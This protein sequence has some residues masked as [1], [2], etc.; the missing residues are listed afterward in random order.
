M[1]RPAHVHLGAMLL[2]LGTCTAPTVAVAES[3]GEISAIQNAARHGNQGA[4][5]LLALIYF[6][7]RGVSPNPVKARQWMRHAADDGQP[8]AQYLLGNW[9]ADGIAGLPKNPDL[10]VQYWRK[11]AVQGQAQ[12]A[13][14]LA[15]AYLSGIGV[16]TDPEAAKHWLRRAAEAGYAPAQR[17]LGKMYQGGY[18]VP[19][20]TLEG[21]DWLARAA[22]QGDNEA[23][24]L[25]SI[26]VELGE[27]ALQGFR[28]GGPEL[29]AR[30]RSGDSV[31][32]YQL[33][34][35]YETGAWGL[36]QNDALALHWFRASAAQGNRMAMRSLADI[37]IHGLLGQSKSARQAEYWRQR[38]DHRELPEVER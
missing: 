11:G 24:R 17:L 30:A 26:F 14:R 8:Y 28:Q 6:E 12:A 18:G 23:I 9:Y 16:K 4:E 31:A 37:Y 27:D 3:P 32:Q 38:A 34:L 1:K 35:R 29:Q 25:L 5:L 22:A 20:D 10:A 21:K 2:L 7:G 19:K 13:Y 15:E 36:P 33:A